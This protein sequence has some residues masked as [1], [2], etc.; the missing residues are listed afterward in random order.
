[1]TTFLI[2]SVDRD[3]ILEMLK[4]E[5]FVRYSK[6]IQEAYTEEYHA[7]QNENYKRINIE[8]QIQK[9]IL[10]KF[11]FTDDN[12]SLTEYWKIPSTYWNDDEV[13]NSIFYMKLNIFQYPKVKLDDDLIDTVLLDYKTEKE[14]N[15]S[16]LQNTDRPLVLLA[17]SMT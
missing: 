3:K 16:S 5:Q 14:I 7:S 6:G 9:F 1:M 15:L 13:K 8:Q 2:N 17:G 10:R 4:E 12:T 11:G